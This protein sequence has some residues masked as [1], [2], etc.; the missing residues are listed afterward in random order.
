[1]DFPVA[2]TASNLSGIDDAFDSVARMHCNERIAG[3]ALGIPF[4]KTHFNTAVPEVCVRFL[5]IEFGTL[6][7]RFR[8]RS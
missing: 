4:R 6:D 7:R 3:E 8:A 5:K 1:M 2:K